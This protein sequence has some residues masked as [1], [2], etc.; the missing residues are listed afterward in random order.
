M[1]ED[2]S[3]LTLVTYVTESAASD[4][5][6]A[7]DPYPLAFVDRHLITF[8]TPVA[9]SL[10]GLRRRRSDV[11]RTWESAPSPI[12]SILKQPGELRPLAGFLVLEIHVDIL[13]VPRGL[14]N[15]IRPIGN[16]VV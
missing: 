4:L 13:A 7:S 8:I 1:P 6:T 14:A 15:A 11:S 12:Q 2:A 9:S 16:V 10:T 3:F 5:Q